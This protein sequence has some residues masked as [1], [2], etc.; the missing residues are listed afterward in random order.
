MIKLIKNKKC[1][2]ACVY[3]IYILIHMRTDIFAKEVINIVK[4]DIYEPCEE[5]IEILAQGLQE[6]RNNDVTA[7]PPDEMEQKASNIRDLENT[8][9]NQDIYIRAQEIGIGEILTY[10]EIC[11]RLE[12]PRYN[13]N[14][15]KAQIKEFLR[16]FDFDKEGTKYII[17]E[18]YDVPLPP[19]LKVPAN[20]LYSRHIKIILLSYLLRQDLNSPVYISSQKLYVAL[21]MVNHNYITMQRPDQKALLRNEL[22]A[23]C[24]FADIEDQS[25]N[26]YI[27]NFYDRCRSK[28]STIIKSSLDSLE[29]QN[30]IDHS[31][32]YHIYK[33]NLDVNNE[34]IDIYDGGYST[35][36]ETAA[37]MEIER[38]VM[39]EFGYDYETDIW[40]GDTK[41]YFAEVTQ[42]VQELYPEI[43]SIYR[44]HKIIGTRRNVTKALS[45]EQETQE[46]RQLNE[47]IVTYIDNQAASKYEETL[48]NEDYTKR[49]SQKYLDAQY[50]LSDRLI[51]INTD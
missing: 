10:K 19:E 27:K 38:D 3:Y 44:C 30:Y 20:S 42:R 40:F 25:L 48:G 29:K 37:I 43:H 22:R 26:F 13:G 46:M 23:K 33:R 45:R 31:R 24:N 21:G 2:H 7:L 17:K 4:T 8:E 36:E 5:D 41:G 9:Y 47:K 50:Y 1:P 39:D 51:K 11:E 15:K 18:V 32:A 6:M 34:E 14:Q 16:Y 35:D 12:Q 49:Y 28:F